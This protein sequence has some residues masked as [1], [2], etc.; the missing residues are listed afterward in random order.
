MATIKSA[1]ISRARLLFAHNLAKLIMNFTHVG[2]QF[3]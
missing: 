3:K 2:V 1:Q